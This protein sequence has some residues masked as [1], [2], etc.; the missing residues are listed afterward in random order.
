MKKTFCDR[1]NK[2]SEKVKNTENVVKEYT[3][4]FN[5]EKGPKLIF[6]MSLKYFVDENES[7][8]EFCDPCFEE[9]AVEMLV[10]STKKIEPETAVAG[11][12]SEEDIPF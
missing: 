10:E 5:F 4:I 2:E 1:C 3:K 6:D 11:S 9:I 8:P 7:Q 12:K